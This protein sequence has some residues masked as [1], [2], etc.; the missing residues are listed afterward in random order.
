MDAVKTIEIP[1]WVKADATQKVM[2][3][4]G[5][6]EI[7]ARSLFVGGAVRNI[8]M[9]KS[10]HDIDIATQL[11]PEEVMERLTA[12]GIK[13]VPTGID[14]G[15]V[16]AIVDKSVYEITTLR[17]DDKT[18]GRRAIVSFSKDWVEDAKRRDFTLNTLL[19]DCEGHVYDPLSKGLKNLEKSKVIFVGE[20]EKRIQEDYLRILRFFR[21][22]A[23]YG[24]GGLDPSGLKACAVHADHIKSLSRERITQ[25]FF[26]ILSVDNPVNVL[27]IMHE[28][29][30]LLGVYDKN[31]DA[32]TLAR[33]CMY[34][35]QYDC[36]DVMTRLFVLAGNKARFFDDYLR[37]SH[38]QKKAIIKIDMAVNTLRY[39]D[40]KEI[41]KSIFHH[42]NDVVLQGY[43]LTCA[44]KSIEPDEALLDVL[45]KWQAP[46]CPIT[47][48][49]LLD[50]GYETGPE[51]GRELQYRIEEW[52]EE[53]L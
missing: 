46:I 24:E 48:Q 44:I 20:P 27:K 10:V 11:K 8:L 3:T 16:S 34:Q 15:T 50:E 13:V 33:L 39:Q 45:Q 19:M 40:K 42:G 28:N 14:H 25:E 26:K 30:V 53:V 22:Y 23:Q 5:G 9:D 51:I 52:L 1:D 35:S 37:L 4:I 41:K 31:Y 21:F 17:S 7:P 12:A 18:D 2:E 38:V 43:L 47:G 29:N 6:L 49:T 32:E 36:I